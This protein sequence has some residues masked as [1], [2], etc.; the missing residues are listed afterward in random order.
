M[1][2]NQEPSL[3]D[4]MKAMDN[5]TKQLKESIATQIGQAVTQL[6]TK[7]D[8]NSR[9][10]DEMDRQMKSINPDNIKATINELVVEKFAE[11][12]IDPA[13]SITESEGEAWTHP[14]NHKEE[15]YIKARKSLRI[16]PIHGQSQADLWNASEQFVT[17][18]LGVQDITDDD[19]LMIR[20][21]KSA[22]RSVATNEVLIRFK[23]IQARDTVY[24]NANR[25]SSHFDN[26]K[27]PTA[28]IKIEVPDHLLGIFKL[29]HRH[30]HQLRDRYGPEF[31]RHVRFW[32]EEQSLRLEVRFP[33]TTEWERITPQLAR[34]LEAQQKVRS[35]HRIRERLS[36]S[37]LDSEEAYPRTSRATGANASPLSLPSSPA[38]ASLGRPPSGWGQRHK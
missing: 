22:R 28:G 25:L 2:G 38:L 34:E 16:W 35:D 23:T 27:R 32:D 8:A 15:E 4:L 36:Q 21:I 12:K 10:L 7:V 31:K 20:R 37:S 6:S 9:R 30:G 26:N 17:K 1:S 3:Q 18:T 13:R 29:L 19:I 11:A 14:G 33:G 24:A 5:N